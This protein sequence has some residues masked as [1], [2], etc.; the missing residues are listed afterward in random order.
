MIIIGCWSIVDWV[1]A[2][3]IWLGTIVWGIKW[4]IGMEQVKQEIKETNKLPW[5]KDNKKQK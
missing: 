4:G 5:K 3:I 1:S 2:S